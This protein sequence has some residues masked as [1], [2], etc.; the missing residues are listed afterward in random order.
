MA[1][2]KMIKKRFDFRNET[3]EIWKN[4]AHFIIEH[5]SW[6]MP[7]TF[8]RTANLQQSAIKKHNT[9]SNLFMQVNIGSM[10]VLC[11]SRIMLTLAIAKGAHSPRAFHSESFESQSN[12]NYCSIWFE[13]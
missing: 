13:A 9:S 2:S 7:S 8:A 1:T 11:T 3:K 4:A 12:S 6:N 10:E 5:K